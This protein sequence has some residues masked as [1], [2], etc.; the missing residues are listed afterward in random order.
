MLLSFLECCSGFRYVAEVDRA[1]FALLGCGRSCCG[2]SEILGEV[3]KFLGRCRTLLG[4]LECCWGSI[5]IAGV[6][7]SLRKFYRGCRGFIEV[8]E[9]LSRLLRF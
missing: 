2:S 3:S 1:M 4:F 7:L 8:S 6:L 5:E 9:V